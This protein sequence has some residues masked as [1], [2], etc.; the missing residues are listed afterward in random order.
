LDTH[1][2][3]TIPSDSATS[4]RSIIKN[5]VKRNQITIPENKL[6][7][8]SIE[9]EQ[10]LPDDRLLNSWTFTKVLFE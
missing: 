10:F 5:I 7:I 2:A 4:L 8:W 3:I 6:A 9:L 1:T